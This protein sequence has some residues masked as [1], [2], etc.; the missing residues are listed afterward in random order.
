MLNHAYLQKLIWKIK[1]AIYYHQAD[2][3]FNLGLVPD[4]V[5]ATLDKSMRF[6]HDTEYPYRD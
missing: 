4:I 3:T 5:I 2:C 6:I 1:V